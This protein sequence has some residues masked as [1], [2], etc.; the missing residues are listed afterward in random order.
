MVIAGILILTLVVVSDW[1]SGPRFA[2]SAH[3][4]PQFPRQG[5]YRR[6]S[7]RLGPTVDAVKGL[8]RL[9]SALPINGRPQAFRRQRRATGRAREER[10]E[11]PDRGGRAGAVP[12]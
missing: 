8:E 4:S 12:Q 2:V 10:G 1:V 7:A 6:A 9:D 11:S 3:P 5:D